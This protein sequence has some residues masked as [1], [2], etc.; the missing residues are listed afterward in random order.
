M[1][2][3]IRI[4]CTITL[5]I[6]AAGLWLVPCTFALAQ[7]AKQYSRLNSAAVFLEY[8][9]TSSHVEWGVSRKRKFESSGAEY[10][11]R[12][13]APHWFNWT[14]HASVFYEMSVLPVGFLQDQVATDVS[15][16]TNAINVTTSPIY[17]VCQPGVFSAGG[18][19]FNRSCGTRWTYMGGASPV[20]FRVNFGPNRRVQPLIDSHLGFFASNRNVPVNDSSSFN[21][22][23]EFGAGIELFRDHTRSVAIEYRLHH[24]S[25][26]YLGNDNPG[27][28]NQ[29]IVVTIRFG[30]SV[31]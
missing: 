22:T 15:L 24:L 2:I 9:N 12:F 26:G 17:N 18:H 29:A 21:F 11:R 23:F 16:D 7:T 27:V 4:G 31:D 10:A 8:S 5:S 1:L 3:P 14:P 6:V 25:N 20:G 13:N 19:A 30:R 28:D